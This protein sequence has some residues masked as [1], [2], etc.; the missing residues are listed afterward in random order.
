MERRDLCSLVIEKGENGVATTLGGI[1]RWD[2][3]YTTVRH[4]SFT[5]HTQFGKRWQRLCEF[6]ALI[7]LTGGDVNTPPWIMVLFI[8]TAVRLAIHG[9]G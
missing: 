6:W 3:G 4:C 7:K 8:A 2:W 5:V 9:H 1:E